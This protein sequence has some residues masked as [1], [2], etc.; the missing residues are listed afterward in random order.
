MRYDAT[1][2]VGSD[3]QWRQVRS[4]PFFL[5]SRDLFLDTSWRRCRDIVPCDVDAGDQP[6]L[7][8]SSHFRE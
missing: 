3:N 6:F 1:F 8:Q 4:A 5:Q 2:L 7:G